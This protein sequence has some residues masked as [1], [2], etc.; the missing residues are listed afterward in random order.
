[1][2]NIFSDTTFWLNIAN[3]FII[4]FIAMS[5]LNFFFRGFFWSFIKVKTSLGRLVLVR[6]NTRTRRYF[7]TG[8][9]EGSDL[10]Y[11]PKKDEKK[12]MN[13]PDDKEVFYRC[14]GVWWVDVD[15]NKNAFCSVDYSPVAGFDAVKEDNLLERALFRPQIIDMNQFFK[16]TAIGIGVCLIGLVVL[17]ILVYSQSKDLSLL[18][19]SIPA[20]INGL[21]NALP[22]G[23]L[24]T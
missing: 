16:L 24:P 7:K 6:I 15:E 10:I 14:L 20:A 4:L 19:D 23:V 13:V 1:M 17:A 3:N 8:R 22:I 21:K 2:I 5:I 9:I 12:R 18:R 11:K